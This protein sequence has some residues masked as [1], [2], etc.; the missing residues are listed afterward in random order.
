MRAQLDYPMVTAAIEVFA[1]WWK[2][3][4]DRPRDLDYVTAPDLDTI[5]RDIGVSTAD[6]RRLNRSGSELLLPRMMA[7]LH[8]DPAQVKATDLALFRDLQRVCTLCN[9]KKRC[10]RTLADGDAAATY[11]AYCPNALSLKALA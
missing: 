7:A 1:D 6:L 10:A 3:H 5:A 4:R 2:Q 9:C 8:L 11:E